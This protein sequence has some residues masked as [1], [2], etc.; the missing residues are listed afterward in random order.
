MNDKSAHEK[1]KEIN[2]Q[3]NTIGVGGYK[4]SRRDR[5]AGHEKFNDAMNEMIELSDKEKMK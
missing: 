3:R 2:R 1:L 5:C 4:N